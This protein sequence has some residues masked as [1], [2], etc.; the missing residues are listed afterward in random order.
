MAR[1]QRRGAGEAGGGRAEDVEI[2]TGE[3]K[4]EEWHWRIM[5]LGT[6]V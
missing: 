4:V 6:Q 5:R 3:D 2:G 1:R